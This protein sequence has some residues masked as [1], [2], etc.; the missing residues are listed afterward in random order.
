MTKESACPF[1]LPLPFTRAVPPLCR[2]MPDGSGLSSKRR[3]RR[4]VSSFCAMIG[5]P[6]CVRAHHHAAWLE[7]RL[8]RAALLLLCEVGGLSCRA[9]SS[10]A[11]AS[12]ESTRPDAAYP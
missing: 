11:S 1:G 5:I 8:P 2:G 9:S 10:A 4:Y 7:R 3:L 12:L 6:C